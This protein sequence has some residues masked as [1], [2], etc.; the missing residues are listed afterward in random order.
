VKMVKLSALAA[1]AATA[2]LLASTTSAIAAPTGPSAL[3][4]EVNALMKTQDQLRKIA[5]RVDR[6]GG[7]A[8]IYLDAGSKTVQVYWKGQVPAKVHATALTARAQGFTVKVHPAKYSEAELKAE[9]ARLAK[10]NKSITGVG[11]KFDGS[12][13]VVQQAGGVST[14]STIQSAFPLDVEASQVELAAASRLFDEAPFKGGAYIENYT[15]STFQ[16]S[17]SSGFAVTSNSTGADKML[18][19]AHCGDS[20]SHFET[21]L[22]TNV[23]AVETRSVS[24]DTEALATSSAQPYS[25]IGDSIQ[26]ETTGSPVVQYGLPVVGAARTFAGE[27]LCTSGAFSGAVC[28]IRADQV[29]MTITINGFGTIFDTVMAY[30]YGGGAAGGNG[31]SGG[32]VFSAVDQRLTARG[33][34]SAISIASDDL[35]T[36]YGVP[37]GGGRQC[38]AR[39]FFPDIVPQMAVHNVSM[40]TAS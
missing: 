9:A 13:I 12:G 22:G 40:K 38:S 1:L 17:C 6:G 10:E 34:L 11:A 37:A 5:E 20:G 21:G 19:A 2:A 30:H 26:N 32:P 24:W 8:G 14:M 27:W 4:P 28:Q 23:G 39:I 36:C 3:T 35:R 15:G 29:G 31:D 7:F 25:W 16:G 18:T 33:T